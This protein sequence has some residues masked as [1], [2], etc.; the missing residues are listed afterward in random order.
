M[1]SAHIRCIENRTSY[2]RYMLSSD[3]GITHLEMAQMLAQDPELAKYKLPTK[4]QEDCTYKPLYNANKTRHGFDM[5][6]RDV[7]ESLREMARDLIAKGLI[8]N[9]TGEE[10]NL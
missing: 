2:G 7:G 6:F 4:A 3:T 10:G 8:D 9:A 1:C 5:Q